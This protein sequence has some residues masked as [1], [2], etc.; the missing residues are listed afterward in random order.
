MKGLLRN[1]VIN[2]G[3]FYALS[4]IV[5]GVKIL[6]GIP[7]FI[8]AGIVFSLIS[9][10]VKPVLSILTLPFNLVTFGLF[11]CITNAILL[12]LLTVLVPDIVISVFTFPG[13]S[14]AGFVIPKIYFN[15]L[16]AYVVCACILSTI[17]SIIQ[18]FIK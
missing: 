6:G 4:Q 10:F 13:A 5:G 16:F 18:W 3:S 14:V 17:T 8:F 1:I 9:M 15:T 12:Y 11:V 7:T 2:A